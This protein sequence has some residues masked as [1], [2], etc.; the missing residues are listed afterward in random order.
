PASACGVFGLKPTRARN[1]LGPEY[2]DAV[3]GWAVEHALTRSV[4]DSAALLDATAGPAPGDPY[5]CP[6]AGPFLAEV[7]RDPGRLR[8]AFTDKSPY[9][10]AI[11]PEIAAGV[12]DV[13]TMLSKLGHHVEEKAP[14]LPHDPST[15]LGPIIAASTALSVRLAERKYGRKM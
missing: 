4:R 1:P 8:I 7:G 13:A 2:G 14:V 11:D 6:P 12:R 3:S 10:E 5:A 9:G 15:V